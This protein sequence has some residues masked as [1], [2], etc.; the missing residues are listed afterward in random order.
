MIIDLL[1]FFFLNY[2]S[3]AYFSNWI[4][5]LL[6]LQMFFINLALL[7]FDNPCILHAFSIF[8]VYPM[9]FL[10]IIANFILYLFLWKF[11]II[12]CKFNLVI[13]QTI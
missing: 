13:M 8:S 12:L 4:F 6:N 1:Y 5:A 3:F 2:M 7:I 11:I 10:L 9:Y